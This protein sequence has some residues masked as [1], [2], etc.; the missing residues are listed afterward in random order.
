MLLTPRAV[1]FL[2]SKIKMEYALRLGKYAQ[3]YGEWTWW[4]ELYKRTHKWH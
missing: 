1:F 4:V 3:W 2:K